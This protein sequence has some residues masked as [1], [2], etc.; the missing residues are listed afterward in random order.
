MTPAK[1]YYLTALLTAIA[2]I[3]LMLIILVKSTNRKLAKRFAIYAYSIAHWSFFVFACTAIDSYKASFILCVI[4]HLGGVFVPVT[5]LHFVKEYTQTKNR[6]LNLFVAS[7]YALSC[8]FALILIVHP[9]FFIADVVPKLTFNYFPDPGPSFIYWNVAM[10]LCVIVSFG[11]LFNSAV[12]KDGIEKKASFAFF[13]ANI[14]GYVGVIG[15]FLPVYNHSFFPFPFGILG[16]FFFTCVTAYA[17]AKYQL[18]DIEV[19]VKRATVF[20]GLFAFVYG[21]FTIV[22][23]LSQEIFKSHLQWN[24]WVSLIPTVA[25]ITF[26]LRPLENYLTNITEQ[27]LFQKKFDYRELLRTFTNEVLTVLELQKLTEQTINGLVKIIKLEV[28]SILLYDSE[29]KKYRIAAASG[30]RD[31]GIHFTNQDTLIT[32]LR[33]SHLPMLKD[34][35]ADEMDGHSHLREDYKKLNAQLCLPISHHDE[36]VGVLS[37]GMKKS[38]ED[39]SHEDIDILATLARTLGIAIANAQLFDQLSKTQAEAAQR[40]KMAVI[41]TLAAGINHEICNPL[42]IVRGQCEMFLLNLRD[43]IYASKTKEEML[44]I[45]TE[46]MNKVIKETDRATGITKRLSGFAKPA[47]KIDSEEVHV[48]KEADEVLALLAH[49]LKLNNI[50]FSMDFGDDFPAIFADKRQI[51]EVLFNIIRNAAQAMD[52]KN[53]RISLSG[54]AEN[55]SAIIKI[56]DNGSGIPEDKINQIFNPFFTTKEPGKGTGLGLF[57]VKQVIER[58]KGAIAVD[59]KEGE[60]TTFTLTFPAAKRAMATA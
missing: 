12:R 42:G 48:E 54:I 44:Q 13:W 16:A 4:C 10:V 58:N 34:K 19:L 39:Y 60:G 30:L 25:I 37:L 9:R 21:I 17:V 20:A 51:Q 15:C 55:G 1:Y 59:S 8:V 5:F 38:G 6:Y 27:F 28:A 41:G 29:T 43:G 11:V 33:Q 56:A 14:I 47:K 35:S 3:V 50:A 24:Q 7:Q 57:I 23:V 22:T 53:G 32:Y 46:I 52:K 26:A 49:D 36:M 18:L 31:K 2:D 45:S 40:E